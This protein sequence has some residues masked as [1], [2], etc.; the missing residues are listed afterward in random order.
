MKVDI[1][2]SVMRKITKKKFQGKGNDV[3]ARIST[4]IST[5]RD[6]LY[7]HL[8][9]TGMPWVCLGRE[10]D[11]NCVTDD[12]DTKILRQDMAALRGLHAAKFI[13]L[14]TQTRHC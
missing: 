8:A 10:R 14:L 13:L 3:S 12:D 11:G 7:I 6:F 1:D 9:Y 5:S 4:P 2:W